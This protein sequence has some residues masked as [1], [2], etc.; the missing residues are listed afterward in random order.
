MYPHAAHA[1][2]KGPN[3]PAQAVAA[4]FDMLER[5]LGKEHFQHLLRLVLTVN[6]FEP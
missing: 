3:V 5:D 6:G 2:L 1:S 4:A